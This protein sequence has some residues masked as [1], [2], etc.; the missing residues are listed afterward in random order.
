MK[1]LVAYFFVFIV[2][3]STF[4]AIRVG[5]HEMPPLLMAGIRF[6][7]AGGVVYAWARLRGDP[8]PTRVEWRSTLIVAGVLIV[9]CYGTL[10][11][12]EQ[13]VTS[14]MAAVLVG[15]IP[16]WMTLSE[17][18]LLRTVRLTPALIA[19]LLA[20]AAG[21]VV[22]T[23][24]TLMPV[25]T[26]VDRIGALALVAS[27]AAWSVVSVAT[28]LMPMPHS[29][30]MRAGSQMLVGGVALV[31]IAAVIGEFGRFHPTRVSADAWWSLAYLIT[32]G[33]IIA[34]TAYIWLLKHDAPSKVGAY[35]YVNPVVAVILGAL[36]LDE[37]LDARTI[38]GTLLVLAAVA[39]M[40]TLKAHTAQTDV[41]EEMAER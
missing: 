30:T 41:E 32:A 26:P 40:M 35:A 7:I 9:L 33:S 28:R 19:A 2:W 8:A 12:A 37:P 4:L 31:V 11:W 21:V 34:Y 14:G 17:V 10:F 6:V 27:S 22:L 20:G 18:V 5:V 15:T 29:G 36:L 25:G 24:E 39:G 16:M 23:S 3:G 13:R 38:T 1:K